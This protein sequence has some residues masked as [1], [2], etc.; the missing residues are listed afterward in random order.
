M[1]IDFSNNAELSW[2]IKEMTKRNTAYFYEK[3]ANK[4]AT[5]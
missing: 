5:T 3:Y 2:Y 1:I 4:T